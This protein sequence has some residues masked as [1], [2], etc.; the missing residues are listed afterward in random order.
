MKGIWI[1]GYESECEW[2]VK[3]AKGVWV[4]KRNEEEKNGEREEEGRRRMETGKLN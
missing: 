1:S 3:D 2:E 4:G